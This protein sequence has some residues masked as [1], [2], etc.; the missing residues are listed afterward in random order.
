[1]SAEYIPSASGSARRLT[2]GAAHERALLGVSL[3]SAPPLLRRS[4]DFEC[5]TPSFRPTPMSV[6]RVRTLRG[7][8]LRTGGALWSKGK[9]RRVAY[10]AQVTLRAYQAR[11]PP[12]Q[13]EG[14]FLVRYALIEGTPDRAR[15]R[16][17]ACTPSRS[18]R[19]RRRRP[20]PRR[21]QDCP[22]GDEPDGR[23]SR[24][25]RGG[26]VCKALS[27]GSAVPATG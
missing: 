17:T 15:Y 24:P 2:T 22:G 1:M 27:I 21:G 26:A 19:K 18:Q 10:G 16:F 7:N 11:T 4:S 20:S 23:R 5:V 12:Y 25:Y 3:Q 9:P 14:G 6:L 8:R 13:G